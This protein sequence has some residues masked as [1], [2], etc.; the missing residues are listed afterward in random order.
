MKVVAIRF[1]VE[2][3]KGLLVICTHRSPL[4][5]GLSRQVKRQTK[6]CNLTFAIAILP[7]PELRWYIFRR[8]QNSCWHA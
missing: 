7:D 2:I 5:L 6:K 1:G 8:L 4:L 3:A